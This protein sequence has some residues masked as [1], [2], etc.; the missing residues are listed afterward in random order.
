[1]ELTDKM[2]EEAGKYDEVLD[3]LFTELLDSIGAE[4]SVQIMNQ[5]DEVFR[6][7]R[8]KVCEPTY[9]VYDHIY[10]GILR[11]YL[12]KRTDKLYRGDE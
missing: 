6:C 10:D 11:Q 8:G 12:D 1:M 4:D 2:R 7:V 3:S 5:I 9:K